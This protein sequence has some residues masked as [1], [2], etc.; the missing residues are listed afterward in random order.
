MGAPNMITDSQLVV[1]WWCDF[2]ELLWSGGYHFPCQTCF[3]VYQGGC[4]PNF[5]KLKI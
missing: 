5:C 3:S 2:W 1:H 4:P